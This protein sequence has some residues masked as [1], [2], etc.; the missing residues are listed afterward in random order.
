MNTWKDLAA[1]VRQV[2]DLSA[3]HQKRQTSGNAK[4]IAISLPGTMGQIFEIHRKAG[5]PPPLLAVH[6]FVE[7]LVNAGF[8]R[9][10]DIEP[11]LRPVLWTMKAV[12]Y[13]LACSWV[14]AWRADGLDWRE[15]CQRAQAMVNAGAAGHLGKSG[16]GYDA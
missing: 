4:A 13:V 8:C 12:T 2:M 15:I 10:S 9:D 5:N 6:G 11:N 14:E 16:K 1:D 3:E 7:A